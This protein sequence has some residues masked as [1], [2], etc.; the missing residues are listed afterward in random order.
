MSSKVSLVN[1]IGFELLFGI[2]AGK[3]AA[4]IQKLVDPVPPIGDSAM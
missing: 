1:A 4:G 3:R 2:E